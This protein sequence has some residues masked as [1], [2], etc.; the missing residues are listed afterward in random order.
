MHK[1]TI[2]DREQ[3][4]RAPIAQM[5]KD[6]IIKLSKGRCEHGHNFLEHYSC[7][8][9]NKAKNDELKIGFFD[10][11]ASNL[12]ADFGIVLCYC[13][14]NSWENK[15]VERCITKQEL[16]KDLDKQVIV[17][18]IEDFKLYDMI[19]GF[20]STKFDVPF[21]RTRALVHNLA[22]PEFGELFHRDAYY[23]VRNK[24]CLSSNRLENSCRVLTGKTDKTRIDSDHWLHALQGEKKSLDYIVEH[25]RYDV[26]DLEK[27]YNKVNPFTKMIKKSM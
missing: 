27:L 8:L 24:F 14:K 16:K 6:D 4:P 1:Q 26:L 25:C 20:Y 19:V 3:M 17:Q 21:V 13:I 18:L 10:I 12:R 5:K 2:N 22:F 23:M 9:Q 15:I 11:E 7:Y